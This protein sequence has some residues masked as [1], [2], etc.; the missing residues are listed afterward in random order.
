MV[1]REA[2]CQWL[3][4]LANIISEEEKTGD[5]ITI[6]NLVPFHNHLLDVMALILDLP[7][8]P[9]VITVDA[10][11]QAMRIP[12]WL[13]VKSKHKDLYQGWVLAYE[14]HRG[15]AIMGERLG[16]ADPTGRMHW[17]ALEDYGRLWRCWNKRPTDEQREAISW[18]K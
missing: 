14:V 17:F 15:I 3:V 13:D 12:V 4:K 10:I 16:M 7:E 5:E 11:R 2:T 1:D 8:E 9:H 6:R 18:E